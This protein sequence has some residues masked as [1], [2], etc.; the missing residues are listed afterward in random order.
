MSFARGLKSLE[1]GEA[2]LGRRVYRPGLTT[3][4]EAIAADEPVVDL[5]R[6]SVGNVMLTMIYAKVIIAIGAGATELQLWHTP[7]AGPGAATPAPLCIDSLTIAT[8]AADTIYTITGGVGAAMLISAGLGVAVASFCTNRLVLVPG[9][10]S[11]GAEEAT[12][13]G[14]IDWT[15]HYVPLRLDA[16][17]APL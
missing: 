5:F 17:V 12:N 15:L 4:L 3:D 10:I 14:V 6:V 9:I 16:R 7:D 13:T 1:A 11:L 2:A 8:D